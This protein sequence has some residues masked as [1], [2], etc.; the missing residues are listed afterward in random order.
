MSITVNKNITPEQFLLGLWK[1]TKPFGMGMLNQTCPT[2]EIA[3]Q[4]L[5]TQYV[6]YFCGRPIKTSFANHPIYE[7]WLYD[8]DAGQ[9]QMEK[10]ANMLDGKDIDI[11]LLEENPELTDQ[12][13]QELAKKCMNGIKIT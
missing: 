8:R 2:L 9:G 4:T 10:I 3:E 6:D 12:E 13:K 5:K 1:G 11:D 7:T